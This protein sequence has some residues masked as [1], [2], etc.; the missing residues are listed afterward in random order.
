MAQV[1]FFHLAIDLAEYRLAKTSCHWHGVCRWETQVSG[2]LTIT[3]ERGHW[4]TTEIT[5][6]MVV[7]MQIGRTL[8][9]SIS[10]DRF[11]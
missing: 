2:F 1:L 4:V 6:I 7:I 9:G 10:V 5:P 8:T 3:V 11:G